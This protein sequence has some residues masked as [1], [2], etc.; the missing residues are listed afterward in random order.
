MQMQEAA[1]SCMPQHDPTA[2]CQ[3][4]TA[5]C[6]LPAASCSCESREV[7]LGLG[8]CS[9]FRIIRYLKSAVIGIPVR[10]QRSIVL[11]HT[12]IGVRGVRV[13]YKVP[14]MARSMG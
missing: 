4:P 14:S 10:H 6:Q 11:C 12:G 5:N 8:I 1:G 3:L 7:Q 2:N 13:R 9:V